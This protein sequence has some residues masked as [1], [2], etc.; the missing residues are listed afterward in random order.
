MRPLA[1]DASIGIALVAGEPTRERVRS[2]LRDRAASRLLVP[3]LFWL[4]VTNALARRHEYP[5]AAVLDAIHTLDDLDIETIEIDRPELLLVIDAV[6]RHGLSAYDGV[7]LALAETLDADLA[8]ADRRL[9]AA[10]SGRSIFIGSG[11]AI[12]EEHSRYRPRT[13]TW[14]SWPEAGAYLAQ[15]RG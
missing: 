5:G 13:P 1:I 9:A 4:E 8:T 10:A 15:L 12:A 14:P 7:Y 6:E 11:D 3:F 2:L